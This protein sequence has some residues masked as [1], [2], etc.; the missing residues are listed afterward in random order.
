MSWGFEQVC[1]LYGPDAPGNA[2]S[3]K[4]LWVEQGKADMIAYF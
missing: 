3:A 2:T 4:S 1:F